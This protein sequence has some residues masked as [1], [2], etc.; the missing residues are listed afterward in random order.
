[1]ELKF[2]GNGSAFYPVYGNTCAYMLYGKELYLI[3]CG[4][5]VFE[6]LYRL[7]RLSEIEH[8]YVLQTHLHADHVG[9]LGS[10][11]SYFHHILG[12]QVTVVHPRETIVQLLTLEGIDPKGYL[13]REQLPENSAGLKADAVEVKHAEDMHCYG[14]VITDGTERIYYSGDASELPKKIREQFL[15]G[16][17]QRIYHDTAS[18]DLP[19]PSHCY[20]GKMEQWIPKELRKRV[21][22]MHLDSPC[23]EVLKN[24]GFS[25]AEPENLPL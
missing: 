22:C 1:M 12:R 5:T 7:L 9:S 11:I 24:A 20:Y 8:V 25:I 16:K 6:Q 17:I 18:E 2:L 21:Y 15:E 3:D 23:E 14:Y 10:L 13:Y 19:N 4:E